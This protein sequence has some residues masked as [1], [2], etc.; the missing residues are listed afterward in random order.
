MLLQ[1]PLEVPVAMT[2][3]WGNW[4]HVEVFLEIPTSGNSLF[5]HTAGW[6]IPAMC[7]DVYMPGWDLVGGRDRVMLS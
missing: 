3:E 7:V 2:G 4:C 1:Q 5:E 6:S